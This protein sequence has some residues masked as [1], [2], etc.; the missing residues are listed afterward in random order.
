MPLPCPA[1][2]QGAEVLSRPAPDQGSHGA[3]GRR[4]CRLNEHIPPLKPQGLIIRNLE[5]NCLR[6]KTTLSSMNGLLR[7]LPALR[8][9]VPG[10]ETW[11]GPSVGQAGQQDSGPAP[12]HSH[13]SASTAPTSSGW[14][15]QPTRSGEGLLASWDSPCL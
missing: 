3:L 8:S 7:P 11:S 5:Q 14:S 2:E 13:D 6:R 10:C 9:R 4:W 12:W 1:A 15:C